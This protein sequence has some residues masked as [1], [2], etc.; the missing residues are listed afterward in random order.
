MSEGDGP[1][2]D[3]VAIVC[4]GGGFPLAV[5]NAVERGGRRVVL[6]P[7]RGWA[8]P[9]LIERFPHHW[10]S[11]GQLAGCLRRARRE[12]CRDIV[13]IGNLVRP[14]IRQ[15]RFDLTTLRLLPRIVRL[16]R[17]GDNHLLSGVAQIVEEFG[18]RLVG[19]HEVA[20]EILVPEGTLGRYE[21][22]ARDREDIVRGLS[23]I[24]AIGPFD[25]GQAAIV[26]HNRVL[27]IE[28]AE[29]T[30]QMLMRVTAMRAERRVSLPAKIGVLVKAPKPQQDRRFDL[31]SIGTR[32]VEL[33]AEAGLAGIAV[34]AAGA[35]TIDLQQLVQA[36]DSHGLFVVGFPGAATVERP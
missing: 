9:S 7:L 19:A 11:L 21:P 22:S 29:G 1:V 20:P 36:A 13:F 4:G 30:D 15:L 14:S 12:G 33:A 23:L 26:A 3:G 28:A 17:G 32:T 35:I 2:E 5:A 27:A 6:F 10:L 18:L 16:F 24:A 8:D 34:E 25:L 31:P